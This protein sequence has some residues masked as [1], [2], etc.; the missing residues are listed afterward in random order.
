MENEKSMNKSGWKN[1]PRCTKSKNHRWINS[2]EVFKESL[3]CTRCGYDVCEQR[4]RELPKG[5]SQ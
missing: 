2:G 5:D 3:I 1:V 4:Y